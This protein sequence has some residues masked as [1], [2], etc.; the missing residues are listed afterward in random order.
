MSIARNYLAKEIYRST[1]VV[2]LALMGLFSFFTLVEQ[3]DAVSDVFPLTALLYV[4]ALAL[5]ARLY[6][7]LPIGVLIGAILALAG[8]AHRNELAI[9]RVSGLGAMGLLGML[10]VISIPIIALAI[11]VS[12]VITPA[13]EIRYSEANLVLRGKVQG[14]RLVSGYWFKEPMQNSGS[15]VINIG[16]LLSTGEVA[17][18]SIYEFDD[19]INLS[20]RVQ[21][22]RG[23]FEQ[24]QLTLLDIT[25]TVIP[26]DA[27]SALAK[28][29]P[30]EEPIIKLESVE[31]SQLDTSLTPARLVARIATPERMSLSVLWDYISYLKSNQIDASRQVV[32]VWRKMAYPFTLIVMLTIAAPVS[33]MQSRRGGVGAKI[34]IGILVGTVF[35]MISQLMLNVGL[36]YGWHPVVTALLPS[37]VVFVLAIAIMLRMQHQTAPKKQ[38]FSSSRERTTAA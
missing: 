21:A 34:F 30:P 32:A 2:M 1:L 24:G 18:L 15:R 37:V 20:R 10:W 3:L 25:R 9:L 36:L 27:M 12:E 26:A 17:D 8:L 28:G 33:Y 22:K 29:I 5:P 19:G 35:F 23:L 16:R 4:E 7:L 11:L 6:E 38:V 31:K 14:G 13:A